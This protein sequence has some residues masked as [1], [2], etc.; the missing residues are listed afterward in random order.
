MK[1][2][3]ILIILI[4]LFNFAYNFAQVYE[5]YLEE[6]YFYREP[7]AS[8]E[9][10]GKT[11]LFNNNDA[12]ASSYNPSLPSISENIKASYTNS[13]KLY[14]LENA[15]Y[16]SF[17]LNFPI[18]NIAVISASRRLY[19]IGED[20][21]IT[22]PE[23]PDGSQKAKITQ[24]IYNLNI[25]KE[26][27]NHFHLG[28][29]FNYL[30]SELILTK[31]DF[32][33]VNL[34]LSYLHIFNTDN[35]KHKVFIGT[36]INNVFT[37]SPNNKIKMNTLTNDDSY[38]ELTLPQVS[39]WT[40]GYLFE[41]D[42]FAIIKNTKD[43]ISN[44]QIEYADVLNSKKYGRYSI[45]FELKLFE[46]LIGRMGYFSNEYHND[47]ND[48]ITY[49]FGLNIPLK[50]FLVFPLSITVDYTNL[51]QEPGSPYFDFKNFNSLTL[52]INYNL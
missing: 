6:I 20:I 3:I 51:K 22:T 1:I 9:A 8:A 4:L 47:K 36:A 16:H 14:A 44:I 37:Y 39:I 13:E 48:K 38:L 26:I 28:L 19:D 50:N 17:A 46:M 7:S 15:Y 43:I 24:T 18:K 49:G 31:Q 42:G 35:I 27:I 12:F 30:N 5:G 21:Y 40:L 2:K 11:F 45:G 32:Y 23:N 41:Y 33:S 34:G 10:T 52:S 29:G 25:S